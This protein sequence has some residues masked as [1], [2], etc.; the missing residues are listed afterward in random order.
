[1]AHHKRKR[2]LA[3]PPRVATHR[4]RYERLRM[5][6]RIEKVEIE[7][8]PSKHTNEALWEI[9]RGPVSGTLE[10]GSKY[11][12]WRIYVPECDVKDLM[13]DYGLA[14]DTEQDREHYER[15]IINGMSFEEA[16]TST[17]KRK[18]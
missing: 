7:E 5:T 14:V 11:T 10:S 4:S 18:K 13:A 12:E 2:P 15:C 8:P 3:R 17:K 1:M 16:L 6:S 9:I